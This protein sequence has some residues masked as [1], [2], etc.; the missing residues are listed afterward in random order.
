MHEGWNTCA[1][2]YSWQWPTFLQTSTYKPCI[3][4]DEVAMALLTIAKFLGI[5][6]DKKNFLNLHN[7]SIPTWIMS[8]DQ[9]KLW[10]TFSWNI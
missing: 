7:W 4:G 6:L 2:F 5:F 10:V 1:E 8:D 3:T 9:Y